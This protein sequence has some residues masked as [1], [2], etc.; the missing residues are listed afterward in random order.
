MVSEGEAT[1]CSYE[2][3]ESHTLS[4]FNLPPE[5]RPGS[6]GRWEENGGMLQVAD[7]RS[8]PQPASTT[9][10]KRYMEKIQE[11]YGSEEEL[12]TQAPKASSWAYPRTDV[13]NWNKLPQ[14]QGSYLGTPPQLVFP[15]LPGFVGDSRTQGKTGGTVLGDMPWLGM[16]EVPPYLA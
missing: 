1:P 2:G 3:K 14:L 12:V 5:L 4:W 8:W 10:T 9:T 6:G 13:G 11:I 16:R 15:S 7:D